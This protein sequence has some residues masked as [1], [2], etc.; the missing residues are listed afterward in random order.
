MIGVV[1]AGVG[2]TVTLVEVGDRSGVGSGREAA[3]PILPIV[4]VSAVI[5]I[6]QPIANQRPDCFT[7]CAPYLLTVTELAT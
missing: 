3:T 6:A 2:V 1:G 5:T 7:I 4:T